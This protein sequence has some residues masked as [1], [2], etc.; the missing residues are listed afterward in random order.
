MKVPVQYI[1][2]Q[3]SF[4]TAL[5]FAAVTLLQKA[6]TKYFH[7]V[8][9]NLHGSVP[10]ATRHQTHIEEESSDKVHYSAYVYVYLCYKFF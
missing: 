6:M 8:A 1:Q 9:K 7:K 3:L 4:I 5:Q 2:A 10:V